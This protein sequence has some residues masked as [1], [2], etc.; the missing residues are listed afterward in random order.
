MYPRVYDQNRLDQY[1]TGSASSADSLL[2]KLFDNRPES[3]WESVGETDEDGDYSTEVQLYIKDRDGNTVGFEVDIFALFG[4]N[5][6]DFKV[7]WFDGTNWNNPALWQITGNTDEN[8][9]MPDLGTFTAY[10]IRVE[11]D[12]TIVSNEE[13]KISEL[14]VGK[15]RF[16]ITSTLARQIGVNTRQ[17]KKE[18]VM[19]DGGLEVWQVRNSRR[20][21]F[22]QR[23]RNVPQA[24]RDNLEDLVATEQMVAYRPDGDIYPKWLITGL[25]SGPWREAYNHKIG[26]YDI[27]IRFRGK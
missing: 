18:T 21:E 17:Q 23:F 27:S 5:L 26:L 6:K 13:K 3:Y 20:L 8:K 19:A 14:Y 2:Y 4:M 22:T 1:A 12:K 25:F 10:G 9:V 24:V 16:E 7:W 15:Y 11:M